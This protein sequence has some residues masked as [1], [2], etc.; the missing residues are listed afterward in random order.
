MTYLSNIMSL[1][2]PMIAHCKQEYLGTLYATVYRTSC[3]LH[4]LLH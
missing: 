1:V 4:R 3:S 2:Y